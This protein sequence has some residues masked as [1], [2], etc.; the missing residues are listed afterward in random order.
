MPKPTIQQ[1]QLIK[2][3]VDK[4]TT[5]HGNDPMDG[6]ETTTLTALFYAELNLVHGNCTQEEYKVLIQD[7]ESGKILEEE[8]G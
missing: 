3:V 7:I 4:L 8:R 5:E 2:E 1:C 6:D